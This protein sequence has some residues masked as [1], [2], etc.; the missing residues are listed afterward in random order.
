MKDCLFCKIVKGEVSCSKV[1]E[2]ENVLAFMDLYPINKG[3][4]LVIPKKHTENIFDI[5]EKELDKVMRVVRK[6]SSAVKKSVNAGGISICQSNGKDAEQE[7]MH[8]HFHIIP[9]F[10][11][12]HLASWG[13]KKYKKEEMEEYKSKIIS[14]L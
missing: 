9:R 13:H 2:D 7:I 4:V 6:L 11:E 5:E 3:H 8:I 10:G 12:D 1:Y 14:C